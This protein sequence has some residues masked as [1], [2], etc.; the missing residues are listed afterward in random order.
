VNT[1]EVVPTPSGDAPERFVDLT[2]L[3]LGDIKD[4]AKVFISAKFWANELTAAQAIT[5]ILAGQELGV[6]P[7]QA[8][9]EI[10]V[11]DGRTRLSAGLVGALVKR[12][13]RYNYRPVEMNDSLCVIEWF[14][15]DLGSDPIGQSQFTRADADNIQVYKKGGGTKPLTD[16]SNWVNYAEDMLFARAL[17]RGARRFAPDVFGGAIYSP[18]EVVGEDRPDTRSLAPSVPPPR[19]ADPDAEP[20]LPPEPSPV[21]EGQT[22]LDDI[23][24]GSE[25]ES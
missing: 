18:D 24:F 22:A 13:K 23:P 10:Y 15:R 20:E 3:S 16:G 14:D 6:P 25:A 11:I 8:M 9:N 5:K 1:T 7:M 2:H 12:S 17:T 4:I 21:V 19:F